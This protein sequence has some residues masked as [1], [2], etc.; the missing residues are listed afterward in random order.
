MEPIKFAWY[1]LQMLLMFT[2]KA[3][4]MYPHGVMTWVAGRLSDTQNCLLAAALYVT[5]ELYM[6][7][8]SFIDMLDLLQGENLLKVHLRIHSCHDMT[9]K[10]H[11]IVYH[12]VHTPLHS[13]LLLWLRA[14][15]VGLLCGPTSKKVRNRLRKRQQ[16]ST[17]YQKAA[18]ESEERKPGIQ[19][20]LA[21]LLQ[22]PGRF[23]CR[24]S[25]DA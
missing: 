14:L 23:R 19:E 3:T 8:L 2:V 25:E 21:K 10:R 6:I 9:D 4:I 12:M 17:W 22:W 13:R 16:R 11:M 15:P 20:T 5:I 18:S 7:L 1:L 24:F